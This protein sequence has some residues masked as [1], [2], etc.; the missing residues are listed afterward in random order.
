VR[1]ALCCVC[2]ESDD[3]KPLNYV[4]TQVARALVKKALDDHTTD[5]VTAMIVKL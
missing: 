5:N 2:A 4:M 3:P 1:C